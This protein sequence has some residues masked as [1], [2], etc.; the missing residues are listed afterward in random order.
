MYYLDK[1]VLT[2]TVFM[3]LLVLEKHYYFTLSYKYINKGILTL[4]LKKMMK[5]FLYCF[6][7]D[8]AVVGAYLWEKIMYSYWEVRKEL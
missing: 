2:M 7:I 1:L 8:L 3:F 5:R 6:R 4:Y